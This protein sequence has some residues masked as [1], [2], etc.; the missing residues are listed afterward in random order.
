MSFDLATLRAAIARHG[1]VMRVVVAAVEGSAPRETGASML[2]WKGGQSGTIGGGALEFEAADWART[3]RFTR[4]VPLG[5]AMGQCCGGAV[6][7]V[8][9]QFTS[10]DLDTIDGYHMRRIEGSAD[11][12]LAL[13]RAVSEFRNSGKPVFPC[14]VN[15]WFLEPVTTPARALWIYG[16]GHVGRALVNVLSPLPDIDITWVDTGPDRFPDNMPANVA[17]LVATNP[18]DAVRHAPAH[19]E[20]LVLTYSHAFDLEICHAVLSHGFRRAGLIGS[21]TKWA[22]FR[23]RLMA[24]G[25]GPEHINRIDCPIGNPAFGKHPQAIAVSVAADLLSAESAK[26]RELGETG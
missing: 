21:A 13:H 18:A 2:V 10:A 23:K 25:H 9:E 4:R 11:I 15:G 17:P 1:P 16:A 26:M 7:L 24:L 8:A 3:G 19:A 14:L 20:H 6:T 12:P 5:P 22:R